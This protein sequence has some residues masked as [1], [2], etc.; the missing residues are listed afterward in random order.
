METTR[1]YLVAPVTY[2]GAAQ[3]L[4]YHSALELEAGRIVEAPVG[5]RQLLG[6]VLAAS[7][8]PAFATKPITRALALPPL[9]SDLHLL[10]DWMADYYAS[11]VS[12]AWGAMLPA[13][14]TRKRRDKSDSEI[15]PGHLPEH[16]LTP[17]QNRVLEE[18]GASSQLCHLIQGVT[19]SGKTRIYLELTAQALARNQSVIVLVPEI[20][21]TPQIVGAFEE[22]FGPAVL[23]SHSK[24]TEAERHRVWL[25]AMDSVTQGTPR[26]IVGPRSCLFM[27]VSKLGLIVIDECHESTYKQEQHLRYHA[28]PTAARRARIAGA[29]LVLGSATPGVVEVQ[30]A[31]VGRISYSKILQRVNNI[32]QSQG[33]ILDMRNKD[34]FTSSKFITQQ[35]LSAVEDT[36]S[37]GRQALLYINR[38]GSASSQVCSDCGHV[39]TCPNCLLP[40]TFHA[41][42]LRFICHHCNFRMPAPAICPECNGSDLRLLGGGT[43]RIED[44]LVRLLPHARIA[45]LDRDSATLA[46]L[47]SVYSQLRQGK[48]DILVGTQMIAKG[49][50]LPTVDTVGIINADTML[51]LPDFT[52][53]ERTYQLISQVSGRAGRGDRPGQIFIQT[54]SPDHPAITAAA[55]SDFDS[56]AARELE[57]R[58]LLGYP[59]YVYLLKLTIRAS[60]REAATS[61]AEKYAAALKRRTG[62]VAIGPAPAFLE[63][64]R[65][66]YHWV[67]T[68]KSKNRPL[69]TEIAHS[70]PDPHWTADLDPINLL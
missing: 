16:A 11:P 34:L 7:P 18:I 32:P 47:K 25:Q 49:L 68:V 60:S 12:S 3:R 58:R 40:L 14:L 38:R 22:A 66:S 30:L 61:A 43:K 52:A 41:D 28:L 15:S 17:E 2:L 56:F 23:A 64:Q 36:V 50:D 1:Y 20:I 10:A 37:S 59:P 39:T 70:L 19:G 21:L 57:A 31:G 27:P 26:V 54:Y 63:I 35:L 45:R 62:I 42:L 4:T 69:L 55:S 13:G 29:K 44:E 33:K 9:P 5:R 8:K 46:H 51:H 53:A 6:V 24:L 48:I 67:I 65:G